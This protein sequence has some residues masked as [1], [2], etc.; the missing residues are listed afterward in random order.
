MRFISIDCGWRHRPIVSV[1]C[2]AKITALTQLTALQLR[3]EWRRLH[4]LVRCIAY[5]IQELACGGLS[6]AT[7]RK[8]TALT[9]ELQ[10][11]G[12][13]PTDPC[14]HPGRGRG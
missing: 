5:R 9:G 7:Q 13:I 10:K 2:I 6:K 3:A 11:D 1:G 14:P 8:L 4:L 12:S